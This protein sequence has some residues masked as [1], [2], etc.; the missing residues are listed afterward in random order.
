MLLLRVTD[1]HIHWLLLRVVLLGASAT[2]GAPLSS[3]PEYVQIA[4][5]VVVQERIAVMS[6]GSSLVILP[7]RVEAAFA[8]GRIDI[9]SW[10]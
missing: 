5:A 7:L 10:P 8:K 2:S 6:L 3:G 1:V 4:L 9:R